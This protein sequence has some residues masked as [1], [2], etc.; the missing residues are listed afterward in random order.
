MIQTDELTCNDAQTLYR[1]FIAYDDDNLQPKPTVLIIHDWEGRHQ[2]MCDKAIQLA[3]MGYVGI[4]V[5]M[6]GEGETYASKA[7][8]RAHM[9]PMMDNRTLITERVSLAINAAKAHPQVNP[10]L[11]SIMGYCFGGLCALDAARAGFD[12]KGVV[13]F[14][15]RLTPPTS[16][17][18]ANIKAKILVLH[19]FDDPIVPPE[20]VFAFTREM[21]DKKADWQLHMYGLTQHSFTNPTANDDEMGLHYDEKADRRSWASA[22]D[23]LKEVFKS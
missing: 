1:C 19:G 7:E 9:A 18:C 17:I 20:Q 14:H 16:E 11:I 4:A 23:F 3:K 2:F 8:R 15:G 21:T 6:Y 22:S 10:E 12:I 5:D 13:S